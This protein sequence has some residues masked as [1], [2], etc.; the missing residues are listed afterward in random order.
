[1]DL[2]DVGLPAGAKLYL[3]GP[4]PFMRSVRSQAIGAGLPATDIHYEVFGPD[5]W[6]AA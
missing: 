2:T 1:M 4:L 6:L 5:V 3:C